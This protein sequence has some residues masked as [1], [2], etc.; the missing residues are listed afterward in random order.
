MLLEKIV[1][2]SS[3]FLAGVLSLGVLKS[4]WDWKRRDVGLV[5]ALPGRS[6]KELFFHSVPLLPHV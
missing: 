2:L 4:G 6:L 3:G 1:S 5:S